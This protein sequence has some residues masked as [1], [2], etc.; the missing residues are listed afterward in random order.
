MVNLA[1]WKAKT[2]WA[3]ILVIIVVVTLA[4]FLTLEEM[5]TMDQAYIMTGVTVAIV[6]LALVRS[7]NSQPL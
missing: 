2:T 4:I 7:Q 3:G 5:I 1:W 6:V